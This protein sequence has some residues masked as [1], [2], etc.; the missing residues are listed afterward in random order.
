MGTLSKSEND[1]LLRLYL[2]LKQY[3]NDELYRFVDLSEKDKK[4][5]EELRETLREVGV[6]LN[7]T[8]SANMDGFINQAEELNKKIE[9]PL[10]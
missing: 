1:I 7:I 4:S 8:I 2:K 10:N 3:P 9:S 6:G 5:F